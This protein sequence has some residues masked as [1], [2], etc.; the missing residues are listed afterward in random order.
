MRRRPGRRGSGRRRTCSCLA[1]EV[2]LRSPAG[3]RSGSTHP[4]KLILI[5]LCVLAPVVAA[6]DTVKDCA[7]TPTV[8][9]DT[10][11]GSYT[12]K[13]QCKAIHVDGGENKL[14][15]ESVD[16]LHVDGA[17]NIVDVT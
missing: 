14:V 9:I 6:A 8:T 12:F 7:K 13:G 1:F 2:D 3:A 5:S 11:E 17:E 10:G 15:I 4:M 16:E